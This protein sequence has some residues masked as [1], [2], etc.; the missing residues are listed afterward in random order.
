MITQQAR[1][2]I[3]DQLAIELGSESMKKFE[4][5]LWKGFYEINI[6]NYYTTS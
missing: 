3:N 5:F 6:E 1:E 2:F 4:K